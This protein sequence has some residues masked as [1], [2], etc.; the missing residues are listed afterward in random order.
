MPGMTKQ[1]TPTREDVAEAFNAGSDARHAG[2]S[3][4]AN[5]YQ[6]QVGQAILSKAWKEGWLHMNTCWRSAAPWRGLPLPKVRAE[7]V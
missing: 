4:S 6:K 7:T 1:P 2:L 5:P 3:M